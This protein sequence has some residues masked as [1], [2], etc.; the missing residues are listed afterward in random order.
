MVLEASKITLK[1]ADGT[2]VRPYIPET[3]EKN[4]DLAFLTIPLPSDMKI[5]KDE[6]WTL[7]INYTGFIF[8][9]PSKGVYT[10]TNFY[11]FNGKMAYVLCYFLGN[12]S[13]LRVVREFY[14]ARSTD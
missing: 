13:S 12:T 6:V 4:F 10:N 1:K 2:M 7:E 3:I 9:H 11:E 14:T 5:E 8:G